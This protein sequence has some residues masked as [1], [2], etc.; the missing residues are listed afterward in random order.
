M[1]SINLAFSCF[2]FYMQRRFEHE[3]C[4][5]D[6][7]TL[8]LSL[9]FSFFCV[10]LWVAELRLAYTCLRP[11]FLTALLY[12]FPFFLPRNFLFAVRCVKDAIL[13]LDLLFLGLFCVDYYPFFFLTLAKSNVRILVLIIDLNLV[14][15]P[16]EID[17]LL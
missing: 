16:T 6:L 10:R 13:H 15:F 3:L 2:E 4:F 8:F 7:I 5:S 12:K 17:F 11:L 1:R 9:F 14:L